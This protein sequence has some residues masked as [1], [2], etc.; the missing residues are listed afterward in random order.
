LVILEPAAEE[1]VTGLD[2]KGLAIAVLLIRTGAYSSTVFSEG[3]KEGPLKADA[4]LELETVD[5]A[6]DALTPSNAV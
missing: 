3:L 2:A 4:M 1:A 5:F 6:I